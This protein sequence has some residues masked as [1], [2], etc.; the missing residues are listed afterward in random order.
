M[1][2]R[3]RPR[4]ARGSGAPAS[5]GFTLLEVLIAIALLGLAIVPLL[6]TFSQSLRMAE[7]SKRLTQATL[8]AREMMTLMELE[9]FP[10]LEETKG[11][12]DE[13][14]SPEARDFRWSRQVLPPPAGLDEE[15][16]REVRLQILWD[17]GTVERSYEVIDF[18]V[19]E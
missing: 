1:R 11:E 4:P 6:G 16:V 9:P 2:A 5:R 19:R 13:E 14:E 8:I 12:F 10:E 3:I 15:T 18:V 7:S 17:E